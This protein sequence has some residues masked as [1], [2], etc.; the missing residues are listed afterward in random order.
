MTC[1]EAIDFL[2]D[3]LE[4]QLPDDTRARFD[5]HLGA[6]PH[7]RS[8]LH[9]YK[10]AIEL[11]RICSDEPEQTASQLPEELI[12]AILDATKK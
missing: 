7:C 2:A 5:A 6:C 10:S 8:Y 12:A 11:A 9:Q 3:Y 1:R 4:G